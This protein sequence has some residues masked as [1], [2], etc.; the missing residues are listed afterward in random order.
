MR[1]FECPKKMFEI[2]VNRICREANNF[3]IFNKIYGFSDITDE[4]YYADW[5]YGKKYPILAKRNVNKT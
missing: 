1:T 3:S 2:P 5:S 4:T